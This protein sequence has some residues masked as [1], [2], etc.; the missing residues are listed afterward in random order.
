MGS[1]NN[2]LKQVGLRDNF[3][4]TTV[5]RLSKLERNPK[6]TAANLSFQRQPAWDGV[7]D[8]ELFRHIAT[9]TA[10]GAT[11]PQPRSTKSASNTCSAQANHCASYLNPANRIR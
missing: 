2:E 4:Q 11:T 5:I 7:G 1:T 9:S 10:G 6:L 3:G 8:W